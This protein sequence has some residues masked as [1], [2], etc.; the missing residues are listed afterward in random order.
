MLGTR[1]FLP[2]CHKMMRGF[3]QLENSHLS[4]NKETSVIYSLYIGYC[5]LASPL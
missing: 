5:F 1:T 2:Y 3:A 4:A